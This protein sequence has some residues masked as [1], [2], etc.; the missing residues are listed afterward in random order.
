[1]LNDLWL[2]YYLQSSLLHLHVLLHSLLVHHGML[3]NGLLLLFHHR[4]L[5]HSNLISSHHLRRQSISISLTKLSQMRIQT[6]TTLT[7][8]RIN[9]SVSIASQRLHPRKRCLELSLLL[10]TKSI[11]CLFHKVVDSVTEIDNFLVLGLHL[12]ESH[13]VFTVEFFELGFHATV[14]I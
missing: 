12:F 14:S 11:S 13:A 10:G 2:L 7:K 8:V 9:T 4:L 3:V 1:M 5:F 6:Q